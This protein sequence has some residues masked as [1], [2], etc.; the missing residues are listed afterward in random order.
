[1]AGRRPTW[2][3]SC[4]IKGVNRVTVYE[5][6]GRPCL[7]IEWWEA[8]GQRVQR[9]LK[10]YTG[11][12]VPNTKEGR[13][14][15]V[16][17]AKKVSTE[18]Q[19]ARYVE[20]T[21][22]LGSSEVR[23]V[24]DLLVRLHTDKE[25]RWSASHSTA[26]ARHRL[27]WESRLGAVRLTRVTAGVVE[28]TADA[29]AKVKGWSPRTH[30]AVLRY[31]VDAFYYAERKLKWI[32]SLDNLSAVEIPK[33]RSTAKAYTLA[34]VKLLLP[35]LEQ[36]DKRAAWIGHVAWQTGRRLSA[37]R[38]L[39]KSEVALV[40]GRAILRFPAATDK[41]GD[42]G[43]AVV[44]GRAA[45]LTSELLSAPGKY[46]LG[47]RIPSL[48]GCDRWIRAAEKLAGV[49]HIKK[50]AW[51]GLKRRWATETEGK[52]GR[53]KMAG[54]THQTLNRVYVQDDLEPKVR[55]AEALAE[56]VE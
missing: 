35:A 48:G 31:L 51:H 53:E 22:V 39:Y 42:E 27:F 37:I 43:E 44:C 21:D 45:D 1:M 25:A 26:Q 50:R 41:V 54:T 34:E 3:Y 13:M 5:R 18:R 4:G 11:L 17:A 8:S 20:L 15:A 40:D 9:S 33:P 23:S 30:G 55:I 10:Y 14:F 24:G 32:D 46:V 12:A 49:P 38:G 2:R 36:I 6:M 29:E 56:M 47:R 19:Q 52:R 28:K 16:M 7:S